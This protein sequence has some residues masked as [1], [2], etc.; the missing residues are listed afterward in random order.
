MKVQDVFATDVTRD[1][2]PVIYFHEQK[3]ESLQAEVS[4][5]IITGGFG[6]D[7]HRRQ[8]GIHE[9]FVRLL[10]A[11]KKELQK[12]GGP[13][14]PACWISGFYG[15]G[16]SSF[17]KL[18]GLSLDRKTLPNGKP[19]ADAL[20]DR[21]DSPLQAEFRTAWQDLTQGIDSLAVVFDIGSASRDDEQIH[22]AVKRMLASRLG[23]CHS[24][25]VADYELSLEVDGHWDAFLKA[26]Q[27]TL[28]R[29]WSEA[30]LERLADDHFSAVMHKLQP[31]RYADP[32]SWLDT[33]TGSKS[34]KGTSVEDTVADVQQ[35]LARRADGKTVFLVVDE[36]SQYIHQNDN[37]MLKL[38]SFVAALG[39]RLK[40]KVWLLATGQQKL[41][42]DLEGSNLTKLKGRFPPQLRVHLSPTNIRDVVHKRLL[43]KHPRQE[44]ALRALYQQHQA[45]L[46]LYGYECQKLTEN[47]FLEVYPMLPGHVDLVMHITSNLRAR[48]SRMKGDDHAIRG[49]LQLLG[50]LFRQQ[51]L[52]DRPL[53][54]LVTLDQIYDVQHTALDADVQL[55]MTRLQEQV[56]DPLTRRVAKAVA[57]LELIQDDQA[58]THATLIAQTLYERVGD[59]NPLEAVERALERLHS[60][61]LVS[62]SDKQGY[63]IQSSA[64]QEWARERDALSA[65]NA[66]VAELIKEKL[67]SR[68]SKTDKPKLRNRPFPLA[69]LYSDSRGASDDKL[70]NPHDTA[71]L[72][73]DFHYLTNQ[74]DRREEHWIRA[75]DTPQRRDRLVWVSGSTSGFEAKARELVRSR[76]MVDRNLNRLASLSEAK[77]RALRNEETHRDQLDAQVESLL[78]EVFL[79]GALYFRARRLQ[80]ATESGFANVLKAAAE[81]ILPQL[82][83]HFIEVAVTEGELKQLLQPSLVGVSSKFFKD[84][85][86]LLEHDSGK[87]V[88]TCPGE[89]PT[90]IREFLEAEHGASGSTLLARFGGPPWGYAPD[91]VRACVLGLL[92]AQ[93]LQIQPSGGEIIKSYQDPGVQDLFLKDRD[94]KHAEFAPAGEQAIKAPDRVKIRKFFEEW[95]QEEL[96]PDN[97]ALADAAFKYLHRFSKQLLEMH[98]RLQKL[99]P[100]RPTLP[101]SLAKLEAT[102]SKCLLSRQ[103]EPTL[104]KVR[105][106]LNDLRDGIQHLHIYR[107]DLTEEAIAQV[108]RAHRLATVEYAQLEEVGADVEITMAGMTVVEQLAQSCPWRD[109]GSRRGDM[110]ALEAGYREVRAGLLEAQEQLLDALIEQLKLREGFSQ[111]DEPAA[112]AVLRLIRERRLETTADAVSPALIV[113][114]DSVPVRLREG[115]DLAHHRLE[116]LLAEKFR[117]NVVP[118]RTELQGRELTSPADVDALLAELRERL[119]AQLQNNSRIRLL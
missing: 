9:Q 113:L 11:L 22:S 35:M 76:A 24:S 4:E 88:A 72:W 23:Y 83:Q 77:K 53:G 73:V 110:E 18:L 58:P 117:I 114:R 31:D 59:P 57:L 69:V 50:E 85:L 111:L 45:T 67:K 65:S 34:N 100:V 38:Q 106:H 66:H 75:S 91:V 14:L 43:K 56:D 39:E 112:D 19:L 78:A 25:A 13:E 5:Y 92:R 7:D 68:V 54:T 99:A 84:G 2:P 33:C 89:V 6:A 48:S 27:E 15:S 70:L 3:P 63:R 104:I 26:A 46:R 119:L 80:M 96:E 109:I 81:E 86:A 21:N 97:E 20:L 79:D 62:R 93:Q 16:K 42:E 44:E 29:P 64:E 52:G 47:D 28:G 116:E 118:V 105:D 61:N 74:E 94:F 51:K 49:L 103:I 82:Y 102:L 30:S 71:A 107:G 101:P 55:T 32:L 90:R 12:P 108:Q 1:I 37:R 95:T 40:G 87:V 115:S 17:A 98:E 60:L 8:D 36:V 10:T 41:E